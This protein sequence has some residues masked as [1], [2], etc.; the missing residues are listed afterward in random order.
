MPGDNGFRLD[1]DQDAAPCRPKAAEQNPTSPILDSQPGTRLL[2]LE[3][4]QLLPGGKDL[5]A[6][7]VTGAQEGAEA[8]DQAHE[9]C[10]HGSGFISWDP[11]GCSP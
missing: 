2:S 9:E 6:E 1:D 10:N 7:T 8:G 4:T 11:S 3:Y 5:K